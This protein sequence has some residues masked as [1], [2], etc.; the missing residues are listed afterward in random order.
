MEESF[1][2][3]DNCGR[4][5]CSLAYQGLLNISLQWPKRPTIRRTSSVGGNVQNVP[6]LTRPT[7]ARHDAPFHRQGRSHFDA[8][9]VQAVREHGKKATCLREAAFSLR[10]SL[11]RSR[12][13]RHGTAGLPAVALAKAGGFFQH[14][15]PKI[16]EQMLVRLVR[17]LSLC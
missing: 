17:S 8:R 7:Q 4:R 6:C 5:E 12:L 11:R 2:F 14:S 1:G 3:I 9:S 13:G 16:G 10:S 15:L